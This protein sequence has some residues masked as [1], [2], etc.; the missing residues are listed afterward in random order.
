MLDQIRDT[1]RG[2]QARPVPERL[3]ASRQPRLDPTQIVDRQLRRPTGPRRALQRV[4]PALGQLLCPAVHGLAMDAHAPRDL[5]FADTS[6][7]QARRF[8]APSL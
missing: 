4:V 1:P 6:L 3:G 8:V 7:E 2:P 5:G